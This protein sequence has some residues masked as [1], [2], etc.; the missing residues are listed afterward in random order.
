VSYVGPSDDPEARPGEV[1][2]AGLH[3]VRMLRGLAADEPT[4]GMDAAHGNASDELG[5]R[6]GLDPA[7]RDVVEERQ[8][9]GTGADD[10]VCAYRDEVDADAVPPPERRCDRGLRPDAGAGV[11]G[12]RAVP[13]IS[14]TFSAAQSRMMA[15]TDES[16]D[17]R[18]H[19]DPRPRLVARRC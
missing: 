15:P 11:R 6:L 1:E 2:R 16:P 4:T 10:V 8:R 17:A 5:D 12:S 3:E 13:F 7:D 18:V 19:T 14:E 9:L